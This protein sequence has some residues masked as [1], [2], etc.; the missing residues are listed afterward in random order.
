M[1]DARI[2]DQ[3]GDDEFF[4][5]NLT[6]T[7]DQESLDQT[8]AS[9]MEES[10]TEEEISAPGSASE[11][12]KPEERAPTP[13]SP[14]FQHFA[15]DRPAPAP[16]PSK[17]QPFQMRPARL[18]VPSADA[19]VTEPAAAGT[20]RPLTSMERIAQQYH[21]KKAEEKRAK[22]EEKRAKEEAKAKKAAE[23]LK[24]MQEALRLPAVAQRT[25]SKQPL[26]GDPT[27]TYLPLR[28]DRR[29]QPP[30]QPGPSSGSTS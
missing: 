30:G 26:E 29:D 17:A 8:I 21:Q 7:S 12:N 28:Q 18:L 4:D 22:E 15:M 14:T 3:T 19:V 11:E 20:S 16:L 6:V 25:R 9:A 5:A 1:E 10:E 23:K 13:T 24:R 27:K 2:L